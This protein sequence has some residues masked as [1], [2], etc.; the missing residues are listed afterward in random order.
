MS[1]PIVEAVVAQ[2]KGADQAQIEA[3]IAKAEAADL[4]A[5][6]AKNI[7]PIIDDSYPAVFGINASKS[8][9]NFG[10]FLTAAATLVAA[11]I[12]ADA[13]RE[14]NNGTL[15]AL[16]EIDSAIMAAS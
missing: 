11:K 10:T 3:A 14:T 2:L 1:N 5:F 13:I 16:K 15:A 8:H 4:A 6:V 9:A 12:I 7:R